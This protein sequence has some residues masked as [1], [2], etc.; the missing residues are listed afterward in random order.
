MVVTASSH[1]F[2]LKLQDSGAT[3]FGPSDN[4][5]E[6]GS[7][8]LQP[9]AFHLPKEGTVEV[10]AEDQ[11]RDGSGNGT[12]F[13]SVRIVPLRKEQ[14]IQRILEALHKALEL[15]AEEGGQEQRDTILNMEALAR[16]MVES[17]P[18]YG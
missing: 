8:N 17:R 18:R 7:S 9:Q 10:N 4:G 2:I 3:A 16:L 13:N 11:S 1:C 5:T 6:Q 14:L 15:S 12:A